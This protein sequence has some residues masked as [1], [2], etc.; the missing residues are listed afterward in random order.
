MKKTIIILTILILSLM[1]LVYCGGNSLRINSG[2][3]GLSV[4]S[5]DSSK[6][7]GGSSQ[8]SLSQGTSDDSSDGTSGGTSYTTSKLKEEQNNR[9]REILA[10]I[11][12]ESATTTGARPQMA[13]LAQKYGLTEAEVFET[14]SKL[15]AEGKIGSEKSL[16]SNS[17]A[18]AAL[19][20]IEGELKQ[21]AGTRK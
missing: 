6:D 11:F 1:F 20:L 15:T 14:V 4:S 8:E 5:D 21:K 17:H 3:G 12:D 10:A 19:V 16:Q 18:K 13:T 9:D 7:S 2:S